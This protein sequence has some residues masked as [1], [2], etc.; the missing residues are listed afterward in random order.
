MDITIIKLFLCFA[1]PLACMLV[2]LKKEARILML[3]MIIGA[4]QFLFSKAAAGVLLELFPSLGEEYIMTTYVPLLYEISK[5]LPLAYYIL[6]STNDRK[7][8]LHAAAAAGTG[9]AVMESLNTVT[10]NLNDDLFSAVCLIMIY[11]SSNVICSGLVGEGLRYI[12]RGVKYFIYGGPGLFTSVAFIHGMLIMFIEADM[13]LT[14]AI[15]CVFMYLVIVLLF[16][17]HDRNERIRLRL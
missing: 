10:Y 15:I 13:I 6:V 2:L 17:R 5:G 14:G 9:F 4:F 16:F 11:I 7:P 12:L 8:V 3:F 1:I